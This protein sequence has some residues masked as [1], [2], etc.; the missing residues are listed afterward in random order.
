MA[1]I[2]S[3]DLLEESRTD[4]YSLAEERVHYDEDMLKEE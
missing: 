1:G 2:H 3:K 4:C